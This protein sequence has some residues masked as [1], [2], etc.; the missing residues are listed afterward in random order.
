[1]GGTGRRYCLHVAEV[2]CF[3]YLNCALSTSLSPL[4]L[5]LSKLL[6]QLLFASGSDK[7]ARLVAMNSILRS[8]VVRAEEA[9]PPR[10]N[11]PCLQQLWRDTM[12]GTF[13]PAI[14]LGHELE[15]LAC[16]FLRRLDLF[17]IDKIGVGKA[18][19]AVLLLQ[20]LCSGDV[21]PRIDPRIHRSLLFKII[22]AA[23]SVQLYKRSKAAGSKALEHLAQMAPPFGDWLNPSFCE[24]DWVDPADEEIVRD[25]TCLWEQQ[26]GRLCPAN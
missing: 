24:N 10:L 14:F 2:F 18:E 12:R 7:L 13:N 8:Y 9:L 1:M 23:F 22:F 26:V 3:Y 20:M 21:S 5:N 25:N 16:L 6:L 19:A 4:P 15:H 17:L 11:L